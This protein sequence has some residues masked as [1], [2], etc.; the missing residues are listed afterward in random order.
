MLILP[1]QLQFKARMSG[2]D[3]SGG[4]RA[5]GSEQ[6]IQVKGSERM[7]PRRGIQAEGSKRMDLSRGI[8]ADESYQRDPS[9]VSE[10]RDPS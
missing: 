5:E 1:T 4:I 2:R 9:R 6:R 8:R 3:S 10:W 7:D